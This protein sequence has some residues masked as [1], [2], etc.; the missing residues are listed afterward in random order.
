MVLAILPTISVPHSSPRKIHTKISHLLNPPKLIGI[1]IFRILYDPH[2]LGI[3]PTLNLNHLLTM[4]I[5][6]E[7]VS[8][9]IRHQPPF[10]IVFALER[11]VEDGCAVLL[12][13]VTDVEDVAGEPGDYYDDLGAGLL[14]VEALVG[15]AGRGFCDEELGFLFG[16]GQVEVVQFAGDTVVGRFFMHCWGVNGGENDLNG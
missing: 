3:D 1:A 12:A 16:G 9:R 7:V 6:N 2:I 11:I 5:L 10:L 13:L 15:G 14:D 4:Y 8:L